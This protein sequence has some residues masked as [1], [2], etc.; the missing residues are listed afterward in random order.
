MTPEDFALAL[1]TQQAQRRLGVRVQSIEE[2]VTGI[3]QKPAKKSHSHP[4]PFTPVVR[5][6][7]P[8]SRNPA[9]V[10]PFTGGPS[11]GGTMESNTI[12]SH[13]AVARL[14]AKMKETG[15]TAAQVANAFRVYMHLSARLGFETPRTGCTIA[16]IAR[17]LDVQ[18]TQA[19]RAVSALE[20]A[21]LIA[22]PVG[23]REREILAS[24]SY[25]YRGRSARF[26][27]VL[28]EYEKATGKVATT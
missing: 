22:R 17:D 27:D 23:G 18:Y 10:I 19:T 26:G 1:E 5:Y 6:A 24:P 13:K 16:S 14:E 15:A 7:A 11:L 21:D 9:P 2:L 12:V 28:A 8:N 3:R 4:I 20:A 25:M